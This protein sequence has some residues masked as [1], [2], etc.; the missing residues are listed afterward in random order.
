MSVDSVTG[1]QNL[2]VYI[3]NADVDDEVS[4]LI[5]R[6]HIGDQVVELMSF[7]GRD[8]TISSLKAT[9]HSL[10]TA[11][12]ALKY[13]HAWNGEVHAVS[14]AFGHLEVEEDG[15]LVF[16][17]KD[18]HEVVAHKGNESHRYTVD[19]I[20]DGTGSVRFQS[21]YTW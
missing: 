16:D 13:S 4:K 7:G 20:S 11:S 17:K 8:S 9:H 15:H 3:Y 10:G 12:M 1:A 14:S 21:W 5:T 6:S 2:R 18:D 19:A